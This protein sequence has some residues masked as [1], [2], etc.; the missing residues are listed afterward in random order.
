MESLNLL[1]NGFIKAISLENI[2][3]CFIGSVLGTLVGVLPGIGPTAGIALLLPL[4]TTLPPTG[5]IIMLAAI[6]YGSMYG[7]ST[8]AILVNMP[9]E[10]ASVITAMDGYQ[11]ARQGR[12]GSALAI[13]AIGSFVAGTLGLL[14][15]SFSASILAELAL[16]FGPPEYLGLVILAL[17]VVV[18]LFGKSILKGMIAAFLGFLFTI[19][20]LDPLF[21]IPR[22]TFGSSALYGGI[23]YISAIVGL[24]AIAE[25]LRSA[26]Q[27]L[28]VIFEKVGRLL[29]SKYELLAC[30]R[31][32]L[33]STVVGFFLGLIPGCTPAVASFIAYDVEKRASKQPEKFGCGALEGVAAPESANNAITSA[34]F[35]PLFSLG[36]PPT[37][38]L[39]VLLGALMIYGLQPGP[40]LFQLHSDFVW[41]V[42]ASM[43]IG[44]VM[45]LILNLPLV[46]LWA[47]IATI[48]YRI[49]APA[50][51]V[52]CFIGTYSIR[53][54][55]FDVW[56]AMSFGVMGYLM[57]KVDIPIFPLVM[58]L[59]LGDMLEKSVGQMLAI[60][61]GSF[62]ILLGR[63]IALALI[64][65][66]IILMIYSIY[67]RRRTKLIKK[68][69]I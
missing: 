64:G 57:G 63:P 41:A 22:F 14:G 38:A 30:V 46:G 68:P 10:A 9:G 56:V 44:N 60:S 19:P 6:Y 11:L 59:I 51:L 25:V 15:L 66:A 21:G 62:S 37:P 40:L 28:V 48:P 12:A 5:S 4:V 35:I 29:P 47:R 69:I 49:L 67:S 18:S 26:E 2:S 50:I 24:F 39:A 20:G 13:A 45:L 65:A 1:A 61:R 16:T 27:S 31:T 36:I 54:R 8:T 34:G 32:I 23:D 3:Y 17:T 7:G 43:Y 42:I 33:R 58:T 55:M 53:N 52:L